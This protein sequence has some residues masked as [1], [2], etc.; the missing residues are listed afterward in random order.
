MFHLGDDFLRSFIVLSAQGPQKPEGTPPVYQSPVPFLDS[1][2]VR[3][4]QRALTDE[5]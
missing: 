1:V 3:Y 5:A 2:P 4:S